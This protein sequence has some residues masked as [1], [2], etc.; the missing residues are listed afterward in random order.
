MGRHGQPHVRSPEHGST[1]ESTGSN[2]N[3]RKSL[4][5]QKDALA[6]HV[7]IRG[8]VPLPKT[9]AQN[10]CPLG[11]GIIFIGTEGAAESGLYSEHIKE[12]CRDEFGGESLRLPVDRHADT[13]AGV[14]HDAFKRA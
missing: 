6:N 11:A 5:V 3:N 4:S 8:K 14:H 9:V 10:D 13:R 12:V 1:L 2:A 7:W